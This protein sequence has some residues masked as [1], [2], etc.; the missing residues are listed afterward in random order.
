MTPECSRFE[1]LLSAHL[2]GEVEP[3]SAVAALEHALLCPSCRAFYEGSR[4]LERELAAA[5]GP[6]DT[7]PAEEL[8]QG[9]R[10]RSGWEA[11]TGG[12]AFGRIRRGWVFAIAAGLTSVV[13]LSL[14]LL[15]A[16]SGSAPRV[17][18]AAARALRET[19]SGST[20]VAATASEDSAARPTGVRMTDE[21]FVAITRELLSSDPRYLRAMEGVLRE[22]SPSGDRGGSGEDLPVRGERVGLLPLRGPV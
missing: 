5:D 10:R 16:R 20:S 9:V 13:G 2:D 8:W 15:L 12:A 14:W 21:R 3:E 6:A 11:G 1:E 19:T 18:A 22:V 17:E 7:L 4:R